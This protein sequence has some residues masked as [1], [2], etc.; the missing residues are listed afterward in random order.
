MNRANP[1]SPVNEARRRLRETF[2][3]LGAD[4][5]ADISGWWADPALLTLLGP[6]LSGLHHADATLVMAPEAVGFIL[7][8][9]VAQASGAGFLDM[10]KNLTEKGIADPVLIR[11]TPPDYQGRTIPWGVRRR[12]LRPGQRVLFVDDWVDTAAT[13]ETARRLVLDSGASWVG[14]A[15]L[16]DSTSSTRRRD[17]NLRGILRE[18]E[19]R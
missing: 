17:L 14:A 13:A 7:G 5:V 3:W 8:P 2:H 18:H 6:A 1:E 9:L 19:L 11:N 4:R 16:V 15:V 12:R 10:R